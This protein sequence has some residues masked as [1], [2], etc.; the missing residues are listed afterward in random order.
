VEIV[1]DAGA[2]TL[3]TKMSNNDMNVADRTTGRA[4]QRL[5]S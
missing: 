5:W 4:F 1:L 3:T 2:A